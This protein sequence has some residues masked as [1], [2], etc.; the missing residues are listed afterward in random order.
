MH[1]LQKHRK[2]NILADEEGLAVFVECL[3]VLG[4]DQSEEDERARQIFSALIRYYMPFLIT[5]SFAGGDP[6]KMIFMDSLKFSVCSH[7]FNLDL[8]LFNL[9]HALVLGSDGCIITI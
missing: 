1:C 2:L 6:Q 4:G 3:V 9:C 8:Y 7:V 5:H